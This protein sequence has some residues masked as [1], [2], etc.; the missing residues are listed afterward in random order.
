VAET[1]T[2][3]YAEAFALRPDGCFRFVSDAA[4]RPSHCPEPPAW[5]GIFLDKQGKRRQVRACAGHR[6]GLEHA[7]RVQGRG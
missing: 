5:S 1:Q 2:P 4:G 6:S 7:R 3:H